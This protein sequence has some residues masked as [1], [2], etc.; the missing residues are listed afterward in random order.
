M[1]VTN[2]IRK[3]HDIGMSNIDIAKLLEV[4]RQRVWDVLNSRKPKPNKKPEKKLN[5]LITVSEVAAFL[6]LHPNTV[7]TWANEGRIKSFRIGPRRDRRFK[8]EDVQ[9]LIKG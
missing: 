4:S 3:L 9:Q 7:R 1:N 5:G 8:L 6:G 2:V